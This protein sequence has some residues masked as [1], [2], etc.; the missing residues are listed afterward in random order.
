MDASYVVHATQWIMAELVRLFHQTD[1]SS[2]TRIV[3]ALVDRTLPLI[4]KVGG[5]RRVL[6]AKATLADSTLLLL[7]GE[8]EPATDQALARDLKQSRVA[9]Y[10][11]VLKRLDEQLLIEFNP[12]TGQVFLSPKGEKEVEDRLLSSINLP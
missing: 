1:T 12:T 8:N 4:W 11:R 7:Y 6:D 3:D 2:A 5:V 9:N 10:R